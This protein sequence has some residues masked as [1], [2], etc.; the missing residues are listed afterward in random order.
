MA[1]DSS[2]PGID[3]GIVGAGPVG[4]LLAGLL[5]Q[6]GLRV[7][8]LEERKTPPSHSQAIGVTPP[9]LKI[10]SRLGLDQVFVRKGLPIRDCH[11]HGES[12][13]LGCASFREIPD[14]NR[15]IVSLPQRD[16]VAL[17]EE[18]VS[19]MSTV[20]V[21]RGVEVS[22]FAQ[23]ENCVTIFADEESFDA[24]WLIGCDGHRSFVRDELGVSVRRG[25]YGCH[26]VMG[27]FHDET[28]LADEAHLFFT[29]EGAVE[30]FP[31]PGGE[32]RWIVQTPRAEPMTP[33]GFISEIIRRRT[34]FDVPP[35]FQM[36]QSAFSP[37]WLDCE[38][39]VKDRVILCG[40]AAHLMSPIGGQGMNTGWADAEFLAHALSEIVLKG[41]E[42]QRLLR[43][44]ESCRRRAARVATQR[45]AHGMWLGTRTGPVA[46]W[47][48]DHAMRHLLFKGPLARRV[49]PPCS[50]FPTTRSTAS[51]GISL[52]SPHPPHEPPR[53]T[54]NAGDA[55]RG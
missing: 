38:S 45:A 11:V 35:L 42:P 14:P 49:G 5:G 7:R 53:R 21:C 16:N 32:R 55:R 24:S 6:A 47:L 22:H 40:D 33:R 54:R 18:T 1:A 8:V 12:G 52:G 37:R 46:S 3:V 29:T 39:Y 31:L 50:P 44:Y 28:D 9:S 51:R 25:D 27:D 23:N 41:A 15:F 48:R 19:A 43:A 4:L 30:S 20:E 2:S 34:G 36:N 10:L 26:F 13:W 17:M